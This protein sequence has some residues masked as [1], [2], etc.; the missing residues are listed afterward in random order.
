MATPIQIA[1]KALGLVGTSP[2]SDFDDQTKKAGLLRNLYPM[3]R[4][5]VLEDVDWTFAT[6]RTIIT[7]A[8]DKPIWGFESQF[9]LPNDKIRVIW[10]SPQPDESSPSAWFTREFD[11][12]STQATSWAIEEQFI[13][14]Q[15]QLD[16]I[17]VKY[18]F[19][20]EDSTKYSPYFVDALSYALA[21]ELVIPLTENSKHQERLKLLYEDILDDGAMKDGSQGAR[22]ELWSRRTQQVR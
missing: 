1:N 15:E 9:A 12:G 4:D 20:L 5:K 16:Q 22:Q 13:K 7:E 3:M 18:I 17:Y 19:R 11:R 6:K 10:A 21:I 2:I 8:N 14:T